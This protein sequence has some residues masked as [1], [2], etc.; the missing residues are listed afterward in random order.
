V[1]RDGGWVDT[2]AS[3]GLTAHAPA[4]DTFEVIPQSLVLPQLR[5]RKAA[6]AA[7]G[8]SGS[9]EALRARAAIEREALLRVAAVAAGAND[10]DSVLELAA[11]EA[12]RA[13]GG[14]SLSIS[15][16]EGDGK[17]YRTLIN[18]GELGPGEERYPVD[19]VY[20][21]ED[22]PMLQEMHRTGKP[23]FNSLD[24]PDCDPAAAEVLRRLGKS[25]DLGVPIEV[26]GKNWGEVWTTTVATSSPFRSEDVHFLEAVGGQLAS[27]IARAELFSK[28]S[29]LAY[30]DSLTGLANRRAFDERLERALARFNS[31]GTS[32]ALLLCDVDRLKAIND[33]HGHVAGDRALRAVAQNL[34]VAA[35]EMPGS[36]VARLGGDEFCILLESRDPGA[37]EGIGA[38][39]ERLLAGEHLDVS[40]SCGAANAGPGTSS[41]T[42]LLRAADAAQYVAK[43]RGG[44]RVCTAAHVAEERDAA[45]PLTPPVGTPTERIAIAAA[46]TVQRLDGELGDAPI[47]DRL[48][49]VATAYTEAGDF[50]RWAISLAASGRSYLRDVSQGVNRNRQPVGARVKLGVKD[51]E[52]YELDEFPA[53]ARVI[54]AGSGSFVASLGGE[55]G[56]PAE[57]ELLEREGYAGVVAAAVGVEEGVYLLELIADDAEAPYADAEAALTLAVRAA[58]PPVGHERSTPA[59]SSGHTRALELTLALADQL[60]VATAEDEVCEAATEE[61][62][63]AFGCPVVHVVRV[64]DGHFEML[65]ERGPSPTPADWT[66][67]ADAGLLGRCLLEGA[68]VLAGEV[69][70]EPQYRATGATRD[71]RSELAVPIFVAGRPWGVVNLE[72]TEVEA[73]NEDDARLLESVAAQIGGA[74]NAISLY[75]SLDRAY[76]GT[77]EAL[78]AAVDAND[79]YTAEHS[80]SI[81][82]N[83]VAVGSRMGLDG[84]ELRMLRYAAA[85]HDIGKV[86]IPREI[87]TKPGALDQ[88]EQIEIEGHTVTG[89]RILE[90]IEFLE[91]I[92]PVVRSGHECWDG[93]GYPDGLAGEEIPLGA[94][95][96]FACDAYHA[97]TAHRPYRA[98]MPEAA[99]RE[100]LQRG[101]GTQFDPEVVEAFLAVLEEKVAA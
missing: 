63:R 39:A 33:A 80:R 48:E 92:R 8:L 32:L 7:A 95:I 99:A 82:D 16:L 43:R 87:L 72:H 71:V 35:A 86:A 98:A 14:A 74:L 28:F 40:I 88:D 13:I 31:D 75:E 37:L 19:E 2:R 54:A 51:Y 27:A 89:E 90:Q 101:S 55:G 3:G 41:S 91:P 53:T 46:A 45:K 24:D 44:N 42:Q 67:R 76:V 12:L 78:S 11:E 77:A 50:A 68:P 5:S 97:M 1:A 83:A 93:S 49:T 62:Q 64:R 10:L 25:S 69:R 79:S 17:R 47:L 66:Q 52:R 96:L 18:V 30:E 81:A 9:G 65:A 34:V 57:L 73:F 84:D 22:F 94:R 29:R 58:I 70:R 85:F 20:E 6:G 59:L 56:D 100:E 21:V 23:Y 15:R 26:E 36:F 38:T 60:G 4:A 61:L